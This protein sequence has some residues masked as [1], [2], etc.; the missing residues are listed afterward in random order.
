MTKQLISL[1]KID[2]TDSLLNLQRTFA[3]IIRRPLLENDQMSED[4]RCEEMILSNDRTSSH[5]RLQF[6]AR[7]YWWRLKGSF[8][9]DFQTVKKLISNKEYLKLRDEYL[10]LFPSISY[11]L[12]HL[13]ARFPLFLENKSLLLSDAAQYDWAKMSVFEAKSIKP[14]GLLDVQSDNFENQILYLQPYVSLLSLS[15]PVNEVSKSEFVREDS[16]ASNV[17]LEKE[18]AEIQEFEI[19]LDKKETYLA[20]YRLNSKIYTRILS[21][22]QFQ[23]LK[24]FESGISLEELENHV[25]EEALSIIQQSFTEWMALNWLSLENPRSEE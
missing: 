7:Q 21:P 2:S 8:D 10:T 9:E 12:R 17:L 11:T 14:L 24:K 19:S 22:E 20:I 23:I 25:T 13:G 18:E 3:E 4:T 5:G 6:Y 15:Y 1:D 16:S